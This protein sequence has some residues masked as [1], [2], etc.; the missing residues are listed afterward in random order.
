LPATSTFKLFIVY[1]C[2]NF[3]GNKL[4]FHIPSSTTAESD[5][6]LSSDA[7]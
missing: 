7:P 3:R 5:N 1:T 4:G 2:Y 6:E